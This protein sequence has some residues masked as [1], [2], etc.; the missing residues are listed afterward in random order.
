M[1]T[2]W[3]IWL[4]LFAAIEGAALLDPRPNDTLSEHLRGWF[5]TRGKSRGWIVRRAALGGL[6]V[7]LVVHLFKPEDR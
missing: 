1:S 2:L 3:L 5:S 7:W 4:G 6:L